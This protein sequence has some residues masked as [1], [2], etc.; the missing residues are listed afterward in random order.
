MED[1]EKV[2]PKPVECTGC[3]WYDRR[4]VSPEG[5]TQAQVMLIGDY[6]TLTTPKQGIPFSDRKG[7]IL[8]TALQHLRNMYTKAIDGRKRW[9]AL[10]QYKTY[11]VQC[12]SDDKP[13]KGP[14][15]R[16]R[17]YLHASLMNIRPK[18]LIVFGATAFNA[19]GLG[20]MK[21][22]DVRGTF[23]KYK[24]TRGNKIEEFDVFVTF[25]LDAVLAQ[26]GVYDDLVRDLR[27][28]FLFAEGRQETKVTEDD[29][30]TN[31]V[32]PET[33]EEVEEICDYIINYSHE[34][35]PPEKHLIAGDTETDRLEMYDSDAKIIAASFSWEP[36]YATAILMDHPRAKWTPEE[37]VRVRAAVQRVW[38]C[39]KP[40]VLHHEKFDR[41]G[42]EG[43]YGWVLKNVV[44]DT[45]CGEH[46]IE[47]DKKGQYGLKVLTR[48]R[49][50]RYAGY[51]DKVDEI[52]QEHGG[53][54][55]VE[56]A[57]RYRKAMMKYEEKMMVYGPLKE[58][59]DTAMIAYEK[60]V[61]EWNQKRLKEK[62]QAKA[63]KR[64]MN[65]DNYG[66]KPPKPRKPKEPAHPEHK[67]PFD[68]TI[69]PIPDLLQY[70]AIDADVCRQHVLHQN[71]RLNA[72]HKK[73]VEKYT[74]MGRTPPPP[75]KRLMRQHVIPTSKTLA[76]MEFTGFPVDLP[77]LEETD[78]ALAKV[79]A[80]TQQQLYDM[81]GPFVVNNPREV[82]A[83]MFQ[84]GFYDEKAG[85][86][87]VVPIDDDL[88]RTKKGQIKA[89]EKALLYVHKQYGHAFPKILLTHRKANKARNPF[90]TNVRE[91][92]LLLNGRMH[93]TFH[94][95]GTSTGR[96]SSSNE[97]MQNFPKKISDYN[98]K[99]IFVPPP[100]MTLVNTDAKGAEIRLFAAYSND[101]LLINA[102]LD[103][104]DTHSFFT[105]KVWPD[106]SYE[107]I[108]EARDL[109]DEWYKCKEKKLPMPCTAD[110]FKWAERMVRRR[111]NC[112]RVVFGTLY[113]AMA[114]KI[115]ETAGIPLEEAQEV[116]DLMF[117]MFPSIP[118]YIQATQNE[119]LLFGGVYTKTGR[120]RRFPLANVKM[121][122]NRCFRQAV[123]FKIQS[124][125]SDIVLWVMNQ[126][127]PIII[128]DM[129][130]EL[131]A[132]VHDSIVFSVPDQY[133]AQVPDMMQEYGTD[134]VA[135]QFSW[136]PIP[137]IWDIEVGKRY[138]A[139]ANI[140]K[141]LEGEQHE[142][143]VT[144]IED[145]VEGHEIREEINAELRV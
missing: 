96:L 27:T 6:P 58:Q 41:Q 59:Y 8:K 69:I 91:H 113:G 13:P 9:D 140:Q 121:F 18:I 68:F 66:K 25:S 86:R 83:V 49:L 47:E 31:Y 108:E 67:P 51:D 137:F 142:E 114:A 30:F 34:G 105:S 52:R 84:R 100:G 60:A 74:S 75:V 38:E 10:K 20:K 106:E 115:A 111:T 99:N 136:L 139:V 39:D 145:L 16:C 119:V 14:T 124:T 57:K 78:Q 61:E 73:D 23:Q 72:E 77:Y 141:Y 82:I 35:Q 46:L 65:K 81:A 48:T 5:S 129:K 64:R 40:K 143:K 93:P 80:E 55:R 144:E 44:W 103:G 97:N 94:I 122:R 138:G 36:G 29:L 24:F 130:G 104:L 56:E 43:R 118:A 21:F 89:D 90:L 110:V 63:E 123:N 101:Q 79:A 12:V 33:V 132:T 37:L 125:S 88:R 92:A 76:N 85:K 98:I 22:S 11:A 62:E 107:R 26:P 109:V 42:V 120:K 133:L 95:P 7:V 19:L 17:H 15:T 135:E 45:M 112:K 32:I 70:A 117:E 1:E 4:R 102:I 3:A 134:R 126:V 127:A 131:H 87:I 116:I 28:A 50:P 71:M 53:L 2:V 128:N 54:T